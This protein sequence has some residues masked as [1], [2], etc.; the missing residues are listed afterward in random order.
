VAHVRQELAFRAVGVF[1]RFF[2]VHQRSGRLFA[3]LRQRL[4]IRA[5]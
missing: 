4:Q 2:R 1:R 5:I 3:L